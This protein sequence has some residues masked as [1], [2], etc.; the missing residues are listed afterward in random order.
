MEKP[1]IGF[2]DSHHVPTGLAP[3]ILEF[4]ESNVPIEKGECLCRLTNPENVN[5]PPNV[6]LHPAYEN[7]ECSKVLSKIVQAN[8][9]K[10]FYVA[11]LTTHSQTKDRIM[12]EFKKY[13]NV[14][15]LLH[16]EEVNYLVGS[17]FNPAPQTMYM[18]LTE[19]DP[20]YEL[21]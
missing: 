19:L 2:Y 13:E 3:A 5:L 11:V 8:P 15:F 20:T 17:R 6:I 21:V 12:N 7:E 14:N 9:D 16:P 10:R 4:Q 18:L 1:Q